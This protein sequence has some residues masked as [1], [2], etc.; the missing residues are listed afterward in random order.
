MMKHAHHEFQS[1]IFLLLEAVGAILK[2]GMLTHFQRNHREILCPR[3]IA[4]L[5][6]DFD[7]IL[8]FRLVTSVSIVDM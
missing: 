6:M 2:I 4:T 7:V 3:S 8:L 5:N 1:D